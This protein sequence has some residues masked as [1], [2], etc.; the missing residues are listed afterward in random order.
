MA[1]TTYPSIPTD[2]KASADERTNTAH[3][4]T[5]IDARRSQDERAEGE[6]M[7]IIGQDFFDAYVAHRQRKLKGQR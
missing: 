4:I 7:A 6:P 2:F 3:V 5:S 1:T